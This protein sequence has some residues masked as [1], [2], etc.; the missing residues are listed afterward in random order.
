[1]LGVTAMTQTNGCSSAAGRLRG[2]RVRSFRLAG[3]EWWT[4]DRVSRAAVCGLLLLAVGLVFGQTVGFDFVNYDDGAGVYDNRLIT[5]EFGLRGVWAVFTQRHMESWAPLTCLSHLFV[6]HLFGHGAAAHHLI[7]VLLHGAS[8]IL[9]FL[10]LQRMTGRTWPAALVTAIFAVH[11][12]RAESV[13]WVSERKDVLSGFFCML[14]LAAYLGY[15]RAEKERRR[16]NNSWELTAPGGV[17]FAGAGEGLPRR[18]RWLR[19]KQ[20]GYARRGF[21]IGWYFCVLVCF[22]M[23]LAAKPMGV[24]LPFLLLLLDYWPLGR[25]REAETRSGGDGELSRPRLAVESPPLPLSPSPSLRI[26]GRVIW[27]KIP[28]LAIACLFCLLTVRGQETVAL[29]VNQEYAFAWRVGN[30]IISYVVY[31]GQFFSPVNLVPFYP[32]RPLALPSWQVAAAVLTLGG[33]TLGTIWQR[34]QRPYLLVGWLWYLGMLLPVIGLVQFGAQSEADR[35]SYL[36]QIGLSIALIWTAAGV[37]SRMDRGRANS[38]WVRANQSTGAQRFAAQCRVAATED[39]PEH[40]FAR[41]ILRRLPVLRRVAAVSV[42][43]VLA[44]SAWRQTCHWRDSEALWAHTVACSPENTMALDNLGFLLAGRGQFDAAIADYQRALRLRP[45]FAKAHN[46][47]GNALAGRGRTD[48]ALRHYRR[49]L[50]IRPHFPEAHNNLGIALARR[51]RTQEA[52]AH[53]RQATQI[54]PELA[55]AHYNLGVA[56]GDCGALDEAIAEFQKAL[57]IKPDLAEAYDNLGIALA[58]RGRLDAAI[59]QFHRALEIKPE[60]AEAHDNLGVA[61]VRRGRIDAAIAHFRKALEIKPELAGAR[62]NLSAVLMDGRRPR[63][64]ITTS[65]SE[66]GFQPA[67]SLAAG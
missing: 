31:L 24:T 18:R 44:V 46:N 54:R 57:E 27:E 16:A 32:R 25:F 36:P 26:S 7:N 21:S 37:G 45:D 38:C 41:P 62:R 2:Q 5:S 49:A 66:G 59:T 61:L 29:E 60:L 56:L 20:A 1:L 55:D 3:S 63:P 23:G 39:P 64:A 9:L 43:T 42:L 19:V 22:I 40:R 8:A 11:P 12:L 6:W 28:L 67:K 13:A 17:G 52:I 15:V 30:A 33:V 35:F 53:L 14:T 58:R 34:R 47:L 48:E 51:G 10:V 4:G 65:R 50:E